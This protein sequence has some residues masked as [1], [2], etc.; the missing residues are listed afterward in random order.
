MEEN[1]CFHIQ[2]KRRK[3]ERKKGHESYY[4]YLLVYEVR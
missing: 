2:R 1:H 3:K 4:I